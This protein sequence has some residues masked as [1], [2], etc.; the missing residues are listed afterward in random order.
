MM[1]TVA[2][3]GGG[4]CGTVA[5][6]NLA[7][8]SR[9]PLQVRLI[10][11]GFPTG[12]SIAYGTRRSE[13]LLNVVARN[14]SALSDQPNHFVEWLRTRSEF[15]DTPD[16]VLRETFVP[17]RTYGDYLSSLLHWFSGSDAGRAHVR[18][19]RIEGRAVDVLMRDDGGD[20]LLADGG[21]VAADR[22][23]LATGNLP[24]GELGAEGRPFCHP[25]Y[26]ENPWTDWESRLPDCDQPVVLLGTG[27]TMIDALLT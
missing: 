10:N 23:L 17:R 11:E 13:H 18:I 2:I 12:R 5:A 26:F 25:R 24:P 4:F 1:K 22:V 6:V 3:V 15:A 20:V 19:E 14:M 27:L 9:E 21:V 7:R 8:L 16:A